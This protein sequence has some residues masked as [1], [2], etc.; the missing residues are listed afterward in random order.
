MTMQKWVN[1]MRKAGGIIVYCYCGD[2]VFLAKNKKGDPIGVWLPKNN[3]GSIVVNGE[4][5]MT[6]EFTE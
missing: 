1:V 3:N 2:L 4:L 5:I 6:W